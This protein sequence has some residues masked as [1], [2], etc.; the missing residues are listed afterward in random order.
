MYSITAD[1]L[2][3]EHPD[4]TNIIFDGYR[5]NLDEYY[6]NK[7]IGNNI[8]K[9][10]QDM[11]IRLKQII[12]FCDLNR[13][14]NHFLL[15]NNMLDL[16]LD[17][18]EIIND[19]INKMINLYKNNCK[20]KYLFMSGDINFFIMSIYDGENFDLNTYIDEAY[21]N[22]LVTSK[23]SL[24]FAALYYDKEEKISKIIIKQLFKEDEYNR[25]KCEKLAIKIRE[26]RIK[27][28]LIQKKKI[29][30]NEMCP[31]GSGKKYKKCCLDK[32]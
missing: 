20:P 25:E 12:E 24:I 10:V 14:E 27:K 18:K 26:N 17:N 16:A 9:P 13:P 2:I 29:G 5:E 3:K 1:N 30:R 23:E 15:T 22:L 7:Y 21:A 31:C 19:T 28:E 32:Y 11:P 8:K 4:T 6:N